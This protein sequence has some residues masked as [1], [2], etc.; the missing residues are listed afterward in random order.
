MNRKQ[1]MVGAIA[2]MAS[3]TLSFAQNTDKE[4]CCAITK[5]EVKCKNTV[6]EGETLCYLHN[7]DHVSEDEESVICSGTTKAGNKC[8]LKTKDLTGLCHHHRK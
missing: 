5:K 1:F 7:P 6:K 4:T 3:A 8:K 2:I